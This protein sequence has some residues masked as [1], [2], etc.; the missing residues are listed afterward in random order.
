MPEY[1]I[2]KWIS[3]VKGNI[4]KN[5]LLGDL[6]QSYPIFTSVTFT[7]RCNLKCRH[8]IYPQADSNDIAFGNLQRIDSIIEATRKCG[9][10]DLIHVGRTLQKE[11]LPILKKYQDLGMIL[12]LIDNG[13]AIRSIRDI[14]KLG[15]FFDGGI[16][17]SI[18]GNKF[19]HEQQRGSGSWNLAIS[20]AT[21]LQEVA[22]RISI[23][24]TASK[25]NC[26]S[27][28][29]GF[30]HLR[31][32]LPHVKTWQITT[33]SLS[34]FHR[35]KMTLHKKEMKTLFNDLV[36][37]SN[38]PIA[39]AIYR[40]EDIKPILTQLFSL[41]E[42]TKKYTSV[43]WKINNLVISFFPPSIVISQEFAIDAHGYHISPFSLDWHLGERPAYLEMRD[44][45][46][47]TDP[48]QSYCNLVDNY[49]KT[50]GKRSF[51]KEREIF[52][53]YF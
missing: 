46:I 45:L 34:R 29:S 44:D 37:S 35:S 13:S 19:S 38:F 52:R 1:I 18:D 24:G 26:N 11:H 27:I 40:L 4:E 2:D 10:E 5:E 3:T 17:I 36:S 22:N 33:T 15:L 20:G 16:D 49:W 31:T 32:T 42:M 39:L 21:K 25:V 12:H 30:L 9:T 23:T 43:E 53:N 48:D 41:S 47:L 14:K 8:C 28:V 6:K 51:Q 50:R 7:R